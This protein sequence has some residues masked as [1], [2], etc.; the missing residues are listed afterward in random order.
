MEVLWTAIQDL[1]QPKVATDD[2]HLAFTFLQCLIMGQVT[3]FLTKISFINIFKSN[4]QGIGGAFETQILFVSSN[5]IIFHVNSEIRS[6][7]VM[8]ITL[9]NSI[10]SEE[11]GVSPQAQQFLIFH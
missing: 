11:V 7:N 3:N 4:Q 2:R 9:F 6:C 8:G 5:S 10:Q 1:L